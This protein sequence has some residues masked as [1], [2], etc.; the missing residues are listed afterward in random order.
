M[1]VL[2]NEAK[3][4]NLLGPR[5]EGNLLGLGN[6]TKLIQQRIVISQIVIKSHLQF[7]H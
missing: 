1:T 3:K 2:G 7:N 4:E 6:E 5:V